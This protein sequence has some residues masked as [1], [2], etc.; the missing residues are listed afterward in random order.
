M[1]NKFSN[2]LKKENPPRRKSAAPHPFARVIIR[3]IVFSI[4]LVVCLFSWW[5][6]LLSHDVNS[7]FAR[8]RAAGYPVSGAELNDW[9]RPVPDTENGALIVTQAFA[10]VGTFP[11]ARSNGRGRAS[12]RGRG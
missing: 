10:L 11:D 1:N 7:Q 12:G 5:R 3:V 6:L 9:R 4:L 2:W 8:I